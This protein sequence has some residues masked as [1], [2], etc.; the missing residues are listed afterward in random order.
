M[1]LAGN[2]TWAAAA[3]RQPHGRSGSIS[4]VIGRGGFINTVSSSVDLKNAAI[5]LTC[6][7]PSDR[8]W[9]SSDLLLLATALGQQFIELVG[10][11][12]PIGLRHWRRASGILARGAHCLHEVA[13]LQ[14]LFDI[15]SGIAFT[16]RGEH[17]TT[18][19]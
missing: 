9:A 11:G 5:A 16:A 12:F 10:E 6:G 3:I 13:H 1:V 19:F 4:V 2:R 18:F 15:G 14:P 17:L 8:E 7:I